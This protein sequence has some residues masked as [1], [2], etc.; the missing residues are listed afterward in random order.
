MTTIINLY[1]DFVLGYFIWKGYAQIKILIL[2]LI[3]VMKLKGKCEI[4]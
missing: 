4:Y 3:G 2:K 1:S